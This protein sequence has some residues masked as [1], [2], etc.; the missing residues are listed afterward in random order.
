M[1]FF[2]QSFSHLKNSSVFQNRLNTAEKMAFKE[3]AAFRKITFKQTSYQSFALKEDGSTLVFKTNDVSDRDLL[4]SIEILVPWK[5][6]PFE[7]NQITI[8]GEWRSDIKWNHLISQVALRNKRIL[9]IGSNNGY[10][11]FRALLENPTLILGIEPTFH[12]WA[13]YHFFKQMI[14]DKR[15][16]CHRLGHEDL[17]FFTKQ[18]DVVLCLGVIYHATDPIILLRNIHKALDKRGCLILESQGISGKTPMVLIPRKK[19]AG[20]SGMWYVPTP[21]ALKHWLIRTGFSDVEIFHIHRLDSTE[22]RQTKWSPQTSLENFLDSNDPQKTT[23]G[24]PAPIRIFIKAK[25]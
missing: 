23:E 1:K 16:M 14:N 22:Q 25:K 15:L 5:K 6:G 11:M 7:V 3:E 9:D 18:F 13:Q 12:Y 8:D 10:Y 2:Y 17:H 19:Y 24:Y 4:K 20:A 21:L